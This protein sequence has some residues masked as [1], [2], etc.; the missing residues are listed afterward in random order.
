MKFK[1]SK[2]IIEERKKLNEL[3]D[4]YVRITIEKNTS[5]DFK[6][7]FLIPAIEGLND[8]GTDLTYT[9]NLTYNKNSPSYFNIDNE[10]GKGG[11]R[12]SAA[13]LM[14]SNNVS[15]MNQVS[16]NGRP[17]VNAAIVFA[18]VVKCIDVFVQRRKPH[19]ITFSPY[20]EGL[21]NSYK[22]LCKV[23][24]RQ[25]KYKW[26]NPNA[27]NSD[28]THDF[29]LIHKELYDKWIQN[30]VPIQRGSGE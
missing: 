20:H 25:F 10:D 30:R 18:S 15:G 6:A 21:T 8:T 12:C 16:A 28:R 7:H 26:I 11:I 3:L 5:T 14:F 27:I 2:Q 17:A 29:V 19:A 24:E 9:V 4:R 22:I 13:A 23:G 1:L